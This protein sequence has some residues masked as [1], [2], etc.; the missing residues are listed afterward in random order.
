MRLRSLITLAMASLLALSLSNDAFA[1]KKSKGGDEAASDFTI[2]DVGV[3]KVDQFY[4]GVE[5][6][7]A[8]MRGAQ[9]DMDNANNQLASALG[10]AEGTPVSDALADLAEKAEGKVE[11]A[12]EGTKPTLTAADGCPE[13]VQ[14]AVT[15]AN[16]MV[17]SLTAAIATLE[18]VAKEGAGMTDEAA[19]MPKAITDSS[20]GIKDKAV[21]T[22]TAAANLKTTKQLVEE[23]KTLAGQ[24]QESLELIKST[25]GG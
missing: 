21:A 19:A 4:D 23:S 6:L 7:V 3:P 24:C 16:A 18:G 2:E 9:E 14:D 13:N 17:D 10:L 15:A 5:G 25:F 22:K 11:L 12:L 20:L 8:K 1:G